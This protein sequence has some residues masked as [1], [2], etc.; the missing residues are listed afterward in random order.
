MADTMDALLVEADWDPREGVRPSDADRAARRA[1]NANAIWRHPRMRTVTCDVPA[2]GDHD[3]LVQVR[4]CGVCGT[5]AHLVETDADGYVLFSG[6]AALPVVIGHE[7]AG[8]VVAVGRRVTTLTEG[9]LVAPE[10]ILYCGVCEPCRTGHPNQCLNL[11][12][13]GLTRAGAFARY[14]AVPEKHAWNLSE[15]RRVYSDDA[16]ICEAGA[17]V[18]P[19][20]CAYNGM[21]VS[22]GGF[23]PGARVAVF[24]LGPIGL[25]AVLLARAAGASEIIGFDPSGPRCDLAVALGA[26]VA[27]SPELLQRQG[28][29]PAEVIRERTRG[30]GADMLVEAAGAAERT[31]PEIERSFAPNGKMVYLGRTGSRVRM[32][33]DVLVTQAN[34]VAGARGHAG[35][36]VFPSILRLM[37]ASRLPAEKMITSRVPFSR[38]QDAVWKATERVDGKVMVQFAPVERVIRSSVAGRDREAMGQ[39]AH[40]AR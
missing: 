24:G 1:R 14:V 39:Y 22:A 6:P 10:G 4:A 32:D 31:M 40:E 16:A 18:E 17:L 21:F 35:S 29:S 26:D 23:R 37:A 20:G 19:L 2:I 15:L 7:Y 27:Y 3:V 12:L 38:V 34:L 28:T 30:A 13:T 5:D 9:D 36:G 25:G 33:L 8:E 11:D